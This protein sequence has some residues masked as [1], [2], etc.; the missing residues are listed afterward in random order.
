M[1]AR[2]LCS[3]ALTALLF[4][5]AAHAWDPAPER[6]GLPSLSTA[7]G[8]GAMSLWRNPSLLAFDP[9][10]SYA[11][12]L[13][14]V[15]G[16]PTGSSL[17]AV[18]NRGPLGMGLAWRGGVDTESWWTVSSGL[19][20][21]LSRN[22]AMGVHLG[23]QIPEGADNNFVTWDVGLGWRPKSWLGLSGVA[24][25]I[26]DP[27]PDQGVEERYGGGL[28]LRPLGERLLLGADYLFTG[29]FERSGGQTTAAPEGVLEG[30]I[31]AVPIEGLVLRAY[32]NQEGTVGGG[33]EVFFGRSGL[34]THAQASLS[35]DASPRA[36]LYTTS[37]PSSAHLF[38]SG[39][40][41]ATFIFE[42]P[43]PYQPVSRL[44]SSSTESYLGLLTRMRQAA[45]DPDVQGLLVHLQSTSF[46]MAQVEELRAVI[47]EAQ[48]HGKTVV[49]YM[50]RASGNSDYL[51][52][53]A[54]DQVYLHP[55]GEL[56]L[57]GM[58]AELQFLAGTL[59]LIGIEPQ[60]VKRG[61]YK[62]SPERF[63]H[64][65]ASAANREQ[66]NALL[67]DLFAHLRDGIAEG[68]GR[69]AEQV[70]RLIDQGPFTG[71]EAVDRGLVDALVYPDQIEARLNELLPQEADLD[72]AYAMEDGLSGWRAANEI[73]V[74]YVDGVIVSGTSSVPGLLGGSR[75]AGSETIVRKLSQARQDDSVKAVVLRVDS[76]G[77]SAFA[78]DEIWRAVE[79]LKE[80]G[81]PV[82]VS[83]GGTAASGGYYVAAGATA[84]YAL[85]STITGSI[86]VYSG[87]FS[88]S[89]LYDRIGLNV[90]QYTRGRHAAMYSMSTSLDASELAAMDR[91][92]SD[93]YRQ[94]KEKVERGRG[95]S[96][97]AVEAVARG[98]VWSGAS[99]KAQ[100][101]VDE[102]GGFHDAVERARQEAGIAEDAD[103]ELVAYRSRGSEDGSLTRTVIH[104]LLGPQLEQTLPPELALISQWRLLSDERVWAVMPY[105]LEVR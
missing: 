5:P 86:G 59:E 51:L 25:N 95:M 105:H 74:I 87:K 80:E 58:S 6:P 56:S 42:A 97:E 55:A 75:S 76:P 88:A 19:G 100:G 73:A 32:A 8:D 47:E 62:S 93:V 34:G 4:S 15:L 90:E 21:M 94:F 46:S 69:T 63:T 2:L 61:I 33:L 103:V 79:R 16:S 83:M 45:V 12:L 43:Y 54:A 40:Q 84:I 82:I 14:Q 85:P 37:N 48:S 39:R 72:T 67:D 41:V 91:M 35:G 22:V 102:L 28:V 30:S 65:E 70:S 23:W 1:T 53:S 64:T 3:S 13:E 78:S 10:Q 44:L 60:Y 36:L 92:V 98:R 27:A 9:D 26:G 77:G 24:Q 18:T 68:R 49:A 81:K 96:D 66:I 17:S 52:A 71:Q 50:D 57:I 29:L 99:A 104:A 38:A 11:I 20:M 101:L 89:E 7:G 31:R